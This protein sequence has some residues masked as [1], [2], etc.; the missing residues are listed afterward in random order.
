MDA[1]NIDIYEQNH[2]NTE[3]ADRHR[4]CG[5]SNIPKQ[6]PIEWSNWDE[7]VGYFRGYFDHFGDD[8]SSINDATFK[9]IVKTIWRFGYV[10][11]VV[12]GMNTMREL[13]PTFSEQ[14]REW[15]RSVEE[16]NRNCE[17][18]NDI[19]VNFTELISRV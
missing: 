9:R 1:E 17:D 3:Y 8:T 11:G 13:T 18:E 19:P 6:T 12:G 4:G 16:H 2:A 7:L 15:K 5:S 14:L 10:S